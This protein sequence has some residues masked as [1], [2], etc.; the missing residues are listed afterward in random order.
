MKAICVTRSRGLELRSIPEPQAPPPGH[1]K[2][3]ISAAAINGG[4]KSFL[5]RP[6]GAALSLGQPAFDIWGASAAGEVAAV[7]PGVP[8]G[9]VGRR[10]AMYRSLG[11]G[12]ETIG[13]WCETAQVPYTT[14]LRL[15]DH[16]DPADYSG[17]LVNLI[18]AHA[19]LDKV[20]ADGGGAVLVTAGNSAT[21]RALAVLARARGVC[22]VLLVRSAD[23]RTEL[24]QH[25]I[26]DVLVVDD[27]DGVE[28]AGR[29]AGA[30]GV[31]AVF[32]GVGGV[33]LT[34]LLP[35]LPVNATVYAYGFLGGTEPVSFPTSLL[36]LRN[37]SLRPFSN[38]G[39]ATVR[40]R[41]RL[42]QALLALEQICDHPLLRTQ[43]GARFRLDQVEAAMAYDGWNGS[44]AVLETGARW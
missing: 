36:V 34:R 31:S 20:A 5:Q 8:D 16:V 21:G 10:V 33:A 6:A 4:D 23:V 17:S 11:R 22:A 13:L 2:V 29:A 30:L 3:R 24:E 38:F 37:I 19:F 18:T 1:V 14:C 41:D 42:A 39:S 40:H 32:D 9:Y 26:A 35:Q 27:E 12:P 7:G 44:K 25:G 43:V 28:A 15:P